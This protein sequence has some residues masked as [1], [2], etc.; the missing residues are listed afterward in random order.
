MAW[1]F[2]LFEAVSPSD[3]VPEC[4]LPGLLIGVKDGA[5]EFTDVKEG[6]EWTAVKAGAD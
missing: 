1:I 6:V 3:S 4:S 5:G 2:R